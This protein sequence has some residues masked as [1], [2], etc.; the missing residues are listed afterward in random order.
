MRMTR[1]A[2][3]QGKD[4]VELTKE[5]GFI[6]YVFIEFFLSGNWCMWCGAHIFY[7]H[8]YICSRTI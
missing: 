3:Q 2:W 6:M 7:K 5:P 8:G 1:T 4:Y